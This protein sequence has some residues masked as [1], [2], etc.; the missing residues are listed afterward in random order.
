[1]AN[2]TLIE[3][4]TT[5]DLGRYFQVLKVAGAQYHLDD[6]VDDIVW[7]IPLSDFE[8]NIIREN[9]QRLWLFCQTNDIDPWDYLEVNLDEPVQDDVLTFVDKVVSYESG[10]P[11]S[12]DLIILK[13]G[14]A[15]G[16]D[17]ETICLY[18]SKE[19]FE[20]FAKDG[21]SNAI[22]SISIERGE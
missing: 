4:K 11:S 19:A 10:S 13:N 2:I 8:K 21:V 7:N 12:V 17:A 3:F 15:L 1:M 9:H 14:M 6:D 5:D 20:S 16:V 18:P 22:D